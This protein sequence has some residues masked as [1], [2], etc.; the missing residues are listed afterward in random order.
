MSVRS[1][2]LTLT[3]RWP[4]FKS[5]LRTSCEQYSQHLK[6]LTALCRAENTGFIGKLFENSSKILLYASLLCYNQKN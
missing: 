4:V 2:V 3:L 1:T 5:A 6:N